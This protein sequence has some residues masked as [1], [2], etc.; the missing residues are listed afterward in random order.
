[1]QNGLTDNDPPAKPQTATGNEPL[2]H[3]LAARDRYLEQNPHLRPFQAEI[4]RLLDKSG[5]REG[6][7]AVLGTL[8]QGKL[9]DLRRELNKL[10]EVLL[11]SVPPKS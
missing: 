6:R 2:Q 9:L 4:D 8:M 10:N 11:E 3:A 7:L 5:N 1:M